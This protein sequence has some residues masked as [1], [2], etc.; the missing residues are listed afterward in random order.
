MA[1]SLAVKVTPSTH[2]VLAVHFEH[3]QHSTSNDA[4]HGSKPLTAGS[5]RSMRWNVSTALLNLTLNRGC[6]IMLAVAAFR[7]ESNV[8]LNL[9]VE[10][11]RGQQHNPLDV[12]E[13]VR[14][15]L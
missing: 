14:R 5:S 12:T 7:Y 10:A 11:A 2:S 6:P 1:G 15:L 4:Q 8:G 13:L 9:K 3:E